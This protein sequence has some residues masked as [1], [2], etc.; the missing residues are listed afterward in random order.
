ML[1]LSVRAGVCHGGPID[2]D[3]VF[4]AK[5]EKLLSSELCVVVRDDG[6]RDPKAMDDVKEE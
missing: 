2:M 3:V 1:D 4:I 6:V 5:L